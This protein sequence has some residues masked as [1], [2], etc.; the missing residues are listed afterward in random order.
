L[1]GSSLGHSVGRWEG[2][3]LIVDTSHVDW[4]YLDPYGTPQ[5]DQVRYRETFSLSGA[6]DVLNY[7]ITITDPTMFIEPLTFERARA[8]TAGVELVSYD[9]IA[10][11]EGLTG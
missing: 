7:S 5:S 3:T 9:C 6:G 4:P 10:H 1:E 11:W 8:W 2:N